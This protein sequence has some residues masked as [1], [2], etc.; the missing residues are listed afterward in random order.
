MSTFRTESFPRSRLATFDICAIGK[1]KHHVAAMFEIDVTDSR[2]LLRAARVPGTRITFTAWL[3][4]V[5]AL[6]LVRHP[7]AAAYRKGKRAKQMFDDVNI[8]LAVEKEIE[9]RNVPVPLLIR[10][11]QNLSVETISKQI[12]D[13][14]NKTMNDD[15]MLLHGR[16][17]TAERLY[18][19]LP[20]FARRMVW[21][22]LLRH[23]RTA[24]AKMGNVAVTS[25]GMVG[26]TSGWFIPISVHPVCFGI[27][28]IVRKPIVVGD[29]VQIRDTLNMTIL[30]DHDVIDGA[31]MARFLRDLMKNLERGMGLEENGPV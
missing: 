20:G 19:T 12:D 7:A 23:P 24:F 3:L 27:S 13:A 14:R 1:R 6:T 2:K 16:M 29:T 15:E 9:G 4:K 31:D 21:R 25:I 10:E 26:N 11:V 18:Y 5:I 28:G 17:S 22:Y 8:S 30:L